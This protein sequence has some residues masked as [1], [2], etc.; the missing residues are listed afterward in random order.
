MTSASEL[1]IGVDGGGT[2]TVAWLAPLHDDESEQIVG[3]GVAGP[4]N[5]RAAGFDIA[6]ASIGAAIEAA[7]AD[8]KLPRSTV[9]AMCLCLSGAG[10]AAEQSRLTAWADQQGLSR[11][12]RVTG[13]AEPILAAASPENWGIALISGTGSFA[14]GRN[15]DGRTARSGGWGYLIGDEGSAYA[16]AVAGLRAATQAADGRSPRTELLPRFQ[17]MLDAAAPQD[18]I[19]RVYGADMTRERIASLAIA[20]FE[21]AE[22]DSVATQIID[23]AAD[24]L[25]DMAASLIAPLGL[26]TSQYPLG[27]AGSVLLNQE[28][29]R[30]RV[31]AKLNQRGV[32]PAIASLVADPV[33]GAVVMARQLTTQRRDDH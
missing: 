23:A 7:F 28:S 1:V 9:A 22:N 6:Q 19:E 21:A 14:W 12:T 18:F 4:G 24:Q 15:R 8:A 13:D 31:L 25:A 2:K 5:P 30:E 16:I 32:A 27:F 20:V 3:R 29:L 11:T 33:R 26:P 10:R 17:R